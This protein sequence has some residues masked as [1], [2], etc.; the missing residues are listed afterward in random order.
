MARREFLFTSLGPVNLCK[1]LGGN[2][3]WRRYYNDI[4]KW[5]KTD[6]KFRKDYMEY[7]ERLGIAEIPGVGRPRLDED[8]PMWRERYCEDLYRFDGDREKA[9]IDSPYSFHTI[10]QKINPEYTSYD[11][12]FAEMVRATE[13]K[14][15]AMAEALMIS[16][17]KEFHDPNIKFDRAK[18]LDVQARIA[19]K[20]TSKLDSDRWGRKLDLKTT[21]KINIEQNTNIN[22]TV[23]VK[24]INEQ[25]VKITSILED[26]RAFMARKGIN[27]PIA[28]P[29][30]TTG[31]VLDA[32]FVAIPSPVPAILEPQKGS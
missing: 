17:A 32:E 11:K 7:K 6:E 3:H 13:L 25:H 26:Q 9:S 8:D 18:V 31:P 5:T 28:L 20:I 4:W 29:E 2:D 22:A 15:S 30:I 14:I 21:G 24:T 27:K 23:E 10:L 19:E 16:A 1:F 12:E